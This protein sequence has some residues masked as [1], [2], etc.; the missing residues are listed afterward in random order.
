MTHLYRQ[1]N[2]EMP[3]IASQ[4]LKSL[5]DQVEAYYA[6]HGQDSE[7]QFID[8]LR[9]MVSL[10][11]TRRIARKGALCYIAEKVE[12]FRLTHNSLELAINLFDRYLFN[13]KMC[14]LDYTILARG[15]ILLA[16]NYCE[17][18]VPGYWTVPLLGRS[19][20]LDAAN[21]GVTDSQFNREMKEMQTR[22]IK[23]VD[24]NFEIRGPI[25]YLHAIV[26]HACD[27]DRNIAPLMPYV[28][29]AES[30]ERAKNGPCALSPLRYPLEV[31]VY[32]RT[33]ISI[34]TLQGMTYGLRSIHVMFAALYISLLRMHYMGL[35][36]D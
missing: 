31:I 21:M 35:C 27:G 4:Y 9:V 23:E 17:S 36:S 13:R 10:A 30:P 18:D 15:C 20:R 26:R 16:A 2:R 5:L 28:D 8:M 25:S 29:I 33:V 12:E 19:I 22:L 6:R 1:A 24:C 34:C 14:V 3:A 11:E 32:A 7:R